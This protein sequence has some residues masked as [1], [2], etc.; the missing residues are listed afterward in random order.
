[1]ADGWRRWVVTEKYHPK[2]NISTSWMKGPRFNY[3]G[4]FPLPMNG[5]ESVEKP[6][7]SE[8][9]TEENLQEL[10]LRTDGGWIYLPEGDY[11]S[12][13]VNRPNILIFGEGEES[14]IHGK[15]SPAIKIM[16]H[17]VKVLNVKAISEGNQPGILFRDEYAFGCSIST[18]NIDAGGDGI[19]KATPGASGRGTIS[20]CSIESG[21]Y[22]IFAQNGSGPLNYIVNNR[23]NSDNEFIKWGVDSSI[24]HGNEGDDIL[25]TESS[26]GNLSYNPDAED[27]VMKN[28]LN[29]KLK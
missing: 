13:R 28:D 27:V 23:G 10:I 6:L 2:S 20:N 12:I 5:N 3:C 25:F 16:A 1:M 19:R 14:K 17:N 22:G 8:R 24:L 29:T 21:G 18:V 7:N 4:G 9:L 26:R 11:D 15:Q